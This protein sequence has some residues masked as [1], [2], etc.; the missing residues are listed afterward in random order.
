M[1][2]LARLPLPVRCSSQ[3]DF[4][5]DARIGRPPERRG[6][7]AKEAP[8]P[9]HHPRRWR[10]GPTRGANSDALIRRE[11]LDKTLPIVTHTANIAATPNF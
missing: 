4:A 5:T 8:V 1:N 2:R 11:A 9:P 6:S 10:G 7:D 3:P